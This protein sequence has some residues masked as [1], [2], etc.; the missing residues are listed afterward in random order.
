MSHTQF[1][2]EVLPEVL[3]VYA[4]ARN[5]LVKPSLCSNLHRPDLDLPDLML[6]LCFLERLAQL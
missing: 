6:C 2:L 3:F 5:R 4:L 1:V